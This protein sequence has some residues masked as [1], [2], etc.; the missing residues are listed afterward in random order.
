MEGV[1]TLN[2]LKPGM[3]LEGAVTNVEAFGDSLATSSASRS[4]R[5][6]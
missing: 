1:E 4:W 2:D 3:V 5:S 6:T